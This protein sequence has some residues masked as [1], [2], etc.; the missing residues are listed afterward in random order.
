[1]EEMVTF[2]EVT[3]AVTLTFITS[4]ERHL[5]EKGI[6]L[7]KPSPMKNLNLKLPS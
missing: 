4:Q 7:Q 2:F 6:A 5:G 3:L 1:M